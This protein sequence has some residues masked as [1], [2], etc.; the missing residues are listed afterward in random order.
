MWVRRPQRRSLRRGRRGAGASC[1]RPATASRSRARNALSVDGWRPLFEMCAGRAD[2]VQ[3]GLGAEIERRARLPRGALADGP[4]GR[5][6]PRRP[7][8][9]QRLLPAA[10]GCPGL[11][12]FYFACND[13]LAYDLGVCLNAWCFEPDG[14]LNVTKARALLAGYDAVRPLDGGRGRGAAAAC[15]RRG[16]PLPADPPLRLADGAGGRARRA[17]G[18]AR[19]L[20][21]APLPPRRRRRRRLRARPRERASRASP[22]GPTAPAPAIPGPGGWGAILICERPREGTAA[23]ARRMTTNNRMELTAAIAALEALKRPSRRRF[24]HRLAISPRRHHRL[25]QGLEEERL[26]DR[27]PEAGQE[28]RPLAAARRAR[29][30]ARRSP[31]TGCKGHAGTDG[32]RAR[33]R[34]RPR[35][36]GAVQE[37]EEEAAANRRITHPANQ[38]ASVGRNNPD[39]I[40]GYS[41]VCGLVKTAGYASLTRP[42]YS[43]PE[44]DGGGGHLPALTCLVLARKSPSAPGHNPRAYPRPPSPHLSS[45]PSLPAEGRRAGTGAGR[46]GRDRRPRRRNPVSRAIA[47]WVRPPSR[48]AVRE[49]RRHYDRLCV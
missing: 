32:E 4:A 10:T 13:M 17:E 43:E 19:I 49:T 39:L 24:L 31:G 1:T 35:G 29:R 44:D 6:H 28:R 36:H 26:E 48:G 3:P 15:P 21:E 2:E 23:A 9:R 20:Q 41:A 11:I 45:A 46:R 16:A 7:L 33:R 42:P 8:S 30:D 37:E 34:P 14:S 25:D 40:Q 5:R 12:D 22:S 18:P 38:V 27:R 47:T